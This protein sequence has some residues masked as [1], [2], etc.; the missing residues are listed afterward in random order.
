[1]PQVPT[2]GVRTGDTDARERRRLLRDPPDILITTP[3]SL[4][5]LLT[6]SARETLRGV[7]TVILDE[8]HSVA[9]TKRGAHLMLSLERLEA[10]TGRPFQ[11]IGLS[12]TQRPLE[13]IARFLG[14]F[15]APGVPRDVAVVDAGVRK[16]LDLEVIVPVEDMAVVGGPRRGAVGGRRRLDLAVDPSGAARPDSLASLDDRV[17][18]QPALRRAS[19][20][21]AQRAGRRGPHARPPRI[22]RPRATG[23]GRGRPQGRLAARDRRDLLARARDRHGRGRPG[24][25]GRGARLGRERAAADRAGRSSGRRAERRQA[26]AEVPRRPAADRGRRR[27][28]ARCRDRGHALPAQPARRP[29]AAARGDDRRRGMAGRRA[30]RDGAPRG[31]V[32]RADRRRASA[33]CS[34]C[35]PG[36]TR[37]TRSRSFARASCGTVRPTPCARATAPGAWRSRSGG[38]IPDRGLY[39]VFTHRRLARR[40]AR[41]GMRLRVAPRRGVPAGGERVADRGDHPRPRRRRRPR[42]ASTASSRSGRR[43]GPGG[44]SSSGEAIGRFTRELRRRTPTTRSS[45]CSAT[46]GST[47][48]PRATS[49]STSTSRPR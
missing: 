12:A 8:I 30:R 42:P 43:R 20:R 16:Q 1:M 37:A 5:L 10:E 18:Q 34:T 35:S 45:G 31:A 47:S 27:A 11:R 46:S 19:G 17:R 39:G 32:R 3:E 38:T 40:R 23:R 4:Y 28:D 7:E 29:R 33:R 2:V 49:C 13:E 24:R 25:P 41:R 36:A 9:A 44:P 21:R 22:A 48:A 6:S 15:A 26:H 14:G